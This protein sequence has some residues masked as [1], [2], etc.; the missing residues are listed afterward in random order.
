MTKTFVS[1]RN[2]AISMQYVIEVESN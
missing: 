1:C 2:E